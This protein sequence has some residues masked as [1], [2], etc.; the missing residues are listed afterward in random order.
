MTKKNAV[1]VELKSAKLYQVYDLEFKS[2]KFCF[3]ATSLKDAESKLIG[4]CRYHSIDPRDYE[5]NEVTKPRYE[6]NIHN[7]WVN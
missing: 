1:G 6:N 4:W 5:V 3:N 2:E 7:E